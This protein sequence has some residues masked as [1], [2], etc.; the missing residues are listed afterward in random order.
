MQAPRQRDSIGCNAEMTLEQA[1]QLSLA[2]ADATGELTDSGGVEETSLDQAQCASDGGSGAEP[3][4]GAW[5]ALGAATAACA[6]PCAFGRG[7]TC[8]ELDV[9]EAREPHA[10]DRTAVDS[11][12]TDC[13]EELAVETRIVAG[14][15]AVACDAVQ[16]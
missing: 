2:E 4:R 1:A 15:R 11:G 10:A 7:R 16:P 12:G 14:N 13:D 6:I 8:E 9:F 3:G 5:R